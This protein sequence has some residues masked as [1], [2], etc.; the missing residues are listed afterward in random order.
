VGEP[1]PVLIDHAA[2]FRRDAYV[3]MEHENAFQTGPGERGCSV[4]ALGP[5][6]IKYF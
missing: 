3:S 2:S 1:R 6:Y 5:R 4:Y